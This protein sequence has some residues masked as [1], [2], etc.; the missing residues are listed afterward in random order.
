MTTV[1]PG[2]TAKTAKPAAKARRPIAFP[3]PPERRPE[4]MTSFKQLALTGSAHYVAEHLGNPETTIVTGE[5]YI[6]VIPVREMRRPMLGLRYPDLLVAFNVDPDAFERSNA[7]V[8]EE[9]G[10]PPDFV[11]EIASPSSRRRD[12]V[13]K[14]AAYANL[15]IP[16]YWRF[17]ELAEDRRPK[18]A[19]D[20]LEGNEYRPL[21]VEQLPDGT[22]HGYSPVLDLHLRWE[23]GGWSGTTRPPAAPSPRWPRNAPGPMPNRAPASWPR[24]L[25]A[26]KGNGPAPIGNTPAANTRPASRPRNGPAPIG[27][28]P[29]SLRRNCGACAASNPANSGDGGNPA[30]AYLRRR[31]RLP[32][33][34]GFPLSRE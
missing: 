16:E 34:P 29:A 31:P 24:N 11:L 8:I 20:R 18:L 21:P 5:R 25:P 30:G 9:Q 22:V 14:R 32:E 33:I 28:T 17:D 10:K 4:D 3:Y 6:A 13:T 7:Y 26:G 15:K 12:L 19:G 23:G 27:N 2:I 1:K